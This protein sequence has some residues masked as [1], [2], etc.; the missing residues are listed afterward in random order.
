MRLELTSRTDLALR[1]MRALHQ[2][3]RRIKRSDLAEL[4][5][6]TPDFLARIM[7]RLVHQGWVISGTGP[8]GGYQMADGAEAVTVF[9][10]I[11]SIEEMPDEDRCVLQARSCDPADRC[12]LHDAWTRARK[13][14]TAELQSSFVID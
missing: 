4:L 6:T 8:G 1:A 13:A 12:A 11:S 14:L 9:D 10:L 5:G 2:E 7:G 3:N